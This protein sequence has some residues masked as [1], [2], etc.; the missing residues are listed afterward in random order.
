ML[1]NSKIIIPY[2]KGFD[3]MI[4]LNNPGEEAVLYALRELYRQH[5]YSPYKM[6]KFEEYDLYA[7]NKDF[8]ISDGVITFT[9]GNGK[10]LALKPDVTLSIVKNSKDSPAL[11]RVYYT[12]NVYRPAKGSHCFKELLQVGLECIG[13]MDAFAVDEVLSLCCESMAL[14]SDGSVLCVS[15]LGILSEV[16][17]SVGIA[18]EEQ[19]TAF[20]LIGERNLHELGEFLR[21]KSVSEQGGALLSGLLS[22]RGGADDLPALSALLKGQVSEETLDAFVK[23]IGGLSE[24]KNLRIDFSIV[25]DVHY[26]NGFVFKGYADGISSAVLSGGQ[27]DKLMKKMGRNAGAIGF[28]IYFDLLER[29]L[30][31]QTAFDVD[32]VLLYDDACS[33]SDLK[34]AVKELIAN[35]QSVAVHKEVPKELRYRSLFVMK[36]G[37]AVEHA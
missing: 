11:Q 26:Y 19:P 4:S 17:S 24:Y 10:L 5:G 32:V 20:R 22:F 28:A 9:D 33:L 16:L 1:Y 36:D 8:L 3:S 30:P 6:N 34:N 29:F 13:E 35:G 12:E 18:A 37:K 7:R 31:G 15:H 25:N 14:I 23:V 27:Y 21:E 2:P